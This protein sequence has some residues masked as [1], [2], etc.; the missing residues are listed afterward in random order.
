MWWPV[1]SSTA[2]YRLARAC[3]GPLRPATGHSERMQGNSCRLVVC[4]RCGRRRWCD[5]VEHIAG[6]R[7]CQISNY[8]DM[9]SHG[10]ARSQCV[11]SANL[12]KSVV[13]RSAEEIPTA[14]RVARPVSASTRLCDHRSRCA[15][16]NGVRRG[17]N[18]PKHWPERKPFHSICCLHTGARPR[19]TSAVSA[20]SREALPA[21]GRYRS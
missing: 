14:A 1:R 9:A 2:L 18:G 20:I 4:Q 15:R 17:H 3:H 6:D 19:Q 21:R 8:G 5:T 11:P 12:Q 16:T 13:P 10:A 7:V